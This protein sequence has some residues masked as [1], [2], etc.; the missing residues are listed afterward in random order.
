L[1]RRRVYLKFFSG[2]IGRIDQWDWYFIQSLNVNYYLIDIQ[3]YAGVF[4]VY[5]ILVYRLEVPLRGGSA[6]AA[7]CCR[8]SP[9]KRGAS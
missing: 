4:M 8:I 2:A 7:A 6:K 5:R 3:V 1:W 9:E